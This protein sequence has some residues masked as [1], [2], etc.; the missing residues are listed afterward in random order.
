MTDTREKID[1]AINPEEWVDL[2]G[3]YLYRYALSRLRDQ[4]AARDAV[5]ETF[6]AAIKS[7]DRYDG[8]VE[9]KY[10]L[11][12]IMRFKIVDRIRKTVR[13]Q[14]I[15]D[16]DVE[17]ILD[18]TLFKASGVPSMRP[19]PWHFDAHQALDSEVF[20]EAF[21]QCLDGLKGP[22]RQAFVLKMLEDME[23][24]EVCKVMNVSANNLWVL[25]HR[26]RSQLKKCLETKWVNL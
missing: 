10:W 5:Q 23:T 9:V 1:A 26:A 4:D 14:P 2:Y 16:V 6:L 17:H 19:D 15:V 11:R 25:N 13:E 7:L 12:G 3:D 22:M 18:S 8:R 20:W 24:E 21:N